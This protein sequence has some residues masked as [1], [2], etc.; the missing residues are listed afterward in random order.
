MYEKTILI[1]TFVQKKWFMVDELTKIVRQTGY[2]GKMKKNIA[3]MT[4]EEYKQWQIEINQDA[5]RTLFASNMPFV[6]K[7]DGKV[8]AEYPD[9]QIEILH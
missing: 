5:K 1:F 9:G 4:S 6:Y 7:K 3:N 2:G 8:I